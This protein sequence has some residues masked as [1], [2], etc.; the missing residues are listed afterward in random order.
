MVTNKILAWGG[1]T[2]HGL[3]YYLYYPLYKKGGNQMKIYVLKEYN[4]GRTACVSE[5][6]NMIK[7][8]IC[9]KSYFNPQYNDY[10]IL[11]IWENG[12][13]IKRVEGGDVLRKIAEE[14]KNCNLNN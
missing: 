12:S 6:I 2:V 11:T 3:S 9:D 14:I 10:P 1:A 13:N 4:T 7:K 5:D 8:K